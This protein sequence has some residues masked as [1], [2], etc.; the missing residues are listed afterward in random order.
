MFNDHLDHIFGAMKVIQCHVQ[1]H[2]GTFHVLRIV[3]IIII[4]V[5]SIATTHV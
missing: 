2:I 5:F 1:T 4:V 3:I